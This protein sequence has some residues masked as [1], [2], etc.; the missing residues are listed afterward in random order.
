MKVAVASHS[1]LPG[2]THFGHADTFHIFDIDT[3]PP[4]LVEVRHTTPHCGDGGGD[5]NRLA[6]SADLLLD[7]VAVL[8]ELIGPC[9]VDV[10]SIRGIIAV[11]HDKPGLDGAEGVLLA[12][13]NHLA[14]G[15][16]RTLVRELVP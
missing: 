3:D 7:C 9:A 13:K 2:T 14:A 6:S 15:P 11:E 10:L 4:R 1:A 12:I 8:A 5:Q 16:P